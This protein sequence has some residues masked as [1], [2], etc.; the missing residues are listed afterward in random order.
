MFS[1]VAT[2]IALATAPTLWRK[3][4]SQGGD[5]GR[6][7]HPLA[8]TGGQPNPTFHWFFNETILQSAFFD[9]PKLRLH[10]PL[11]EEGLE[12]SVQGEIGRDY[13]LEVSDDLEHWE[14]V[15]SFNNQQETTLWL[16]TSAAAWPHRF[17]RAVS[18]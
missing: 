6:H 5:R 10:G 9:P 3:P 7:P 1:E 12:F 18:P 15:M 16:D 11:S 14:E 8:A 2:L 17:Y 13:R 4:V